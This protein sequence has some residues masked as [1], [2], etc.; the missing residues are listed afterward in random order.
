MAFLKK[1]SLILLVL[2]LFLLV[3]VVAADNSEEVSLKFM[4]YETS[5]WPVSWWMLGAFV[6]GVLFGTLLNLVSNTK[7]RMSARAAEKA[8][9][10]R[11]R[12]LDTARNGS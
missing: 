9:A 7:L 4:G 3:L 6:P 5:A 2:V 12:E 8:A 10:R 11:T 1:W